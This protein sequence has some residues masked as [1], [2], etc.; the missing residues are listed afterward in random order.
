MTSSTPFPDGKNFDG[1]AAPT[2]RATG[3]LTA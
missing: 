2:N 1:H 3:E